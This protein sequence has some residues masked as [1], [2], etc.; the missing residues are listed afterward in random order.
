MYMCVCVCVCVCACVCVCNAQFLNP[1]LPLL[2][3]LYISALFILIISPSLTTSNS[4]F[5]PPTLY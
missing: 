2:F 3:I 1:N 5:L 4:I